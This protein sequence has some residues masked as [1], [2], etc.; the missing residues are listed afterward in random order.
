MLGRSFNKKTP[1]FA[2]IFILTI[3]KACDILQ[4]PKHHR[5]LF[6]IFN[7]GDY[8]RICEFCQIYSRRRLFYYA[9]KNYAGNL[10]AISLDVLQ[11]ENRSCII[12]ENFLQKNFKN[13]N[14]ETDNLHIKL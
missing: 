5:R 9:Q 11:N 13:P 6:S 2:S 7:Y 12:R 4:V 8:S 1:D 10:G 3:K 14:T